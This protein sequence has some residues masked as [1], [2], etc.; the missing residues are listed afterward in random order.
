MIKKEKVGLYIR[1]STHEQA[2][3]GYSI[4]EQEDRLT[5][6][7]KAQNWTI[8][9]VY[10]DAGISGK[11]IED[12]PALREMI[13]DIKL[14]KL[15]KVLVYK[16][17]RLSR[18]QRDTI[19][20][21]EDLF[22]KYK[23][24]I[25]SMTENLDTST[26]AGIMFIN[27]LA[28]FAQMERDTIKERMTMGKDARAKDGYFHGGG[29]MPFGYD[30]IDGEL[31]IN[32]YEAEQVRKIF[33]LYLD[34]MSVSAITSFMDKKYPNKK[35]AKWAESAVRSVLFSDITTGVITWKG[36]TYD[37]R[38]EAIVDKETFE[39]V[40]SERM[41]RIE[42][43]PRKYS[44]P[45]FKRT[46]LLGGLLWCGNCGA[47]YHC[48][49]NT[50]KRYKTTDPDKKPLRYYMCYS[51]SKT[52]KRMIKDPNCKNP[53]YNV[54]PLDAVIIDQLMQLA[55]DKKYLAK[56]LNE[57]VAK[58]PEINL[59]VIADRIEVIDKQI[60]KLID[61]Y[62]ISDM[63]FTVINKKLELLNQEKRELEL[64][65][66]EGEDQIQE[67]ELSLGE[68]KQIIKTIPEIFE[69][70]TFDE[71]KEIVEALINSIIIY[72]DDTIEINWKFS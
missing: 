1:V 28:S 10:A 33:D 39:K 37:G 7:A 14:G 26:P 63:D 3:E 38:H 29:Y 42:K 70:G 48:K 5:A 32:E 62:T 6:Y 43:D 8:H 2:V 25:V 66:L 23:V 59:K 57:K 72:H 40:Q 20:M 31:V 17:D 27:L 16:L 51:R 12:R 68:A 30:Y 44:R 71:K 53:A 13:R 18:R 36:K 11:N 24:D 65:L 60:K 34:G 61:L 64:R 21:I 45:A 47:R 49:Q 9:K 15:Q 22:I 35:Y 50:V 46:T 56:I 69:S 55:I 19:T 52:Q 58:N 67:P 41:A 4:Q 54:D